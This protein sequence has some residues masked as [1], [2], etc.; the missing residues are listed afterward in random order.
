MMPIIGSVGSVRKRIEDSFTATVADL[1]NQST[2]DNMSGWT[3]LLGTSFG[4]SGG[5]VSTSTTTNSVYILRNGYRSVRITAS[6]DEKTGGDAV[7][8]RV[9]D[10]NNWM[11]VREYSTYSANYN[12]CNIYTFG[13]Y[14]QVVDPPNG[15]CFGIFYSTPSDS[16][17]TS[18]CGTNI[19]GFT[20]FQFEYRPDCFTSTP[21][22]LLSY[23]NFGYGEINTSNRNWQYFVTIEKMEN[24]VLTTIGTP[25][26]FSRKQILTSTSPSGIP[27]TG[28]QPNPSRNLV[29]TVTPT[30]ISY[31]GYGV[32]NSV[33]NSDLS[34]FTGIGIGRGASSIYTTSGMTNLAVDIL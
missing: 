21:W 14:T 15:P 13:G 10:A 5:R 2:P 18:I 1:N 19:V 29:V 23:Y 22:K 6:L 20:N 32:S 34:G 16:G 25:Q 3:K 4:T 26:M 31:S 11:R 9:K 12:E 17:I 30:S 27:T 33:T 28:E 24:G 8:F 7:Y